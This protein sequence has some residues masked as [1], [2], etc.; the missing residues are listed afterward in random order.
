MIRG[1]H[2]VLC[3]VCGRET[4]ALVEGLCPQCF[5]ARHPLIQKK[6]ELTIQHC[7]VCGAYRFGNSAWIQETSALEEELRKRMETFLVLGGRISEAH[8][9][10]H[11]RSRVLEVRVRGVAFGLQGEPYWESY[12]LPFRLL[13]TLCDSC[14][15]HRA[16]KTAAVVQ[17]R[18]EDRDLTV[19]ERRAVQEVLLNLSEESRGATLDWIPIK[20][21]N[22]PHGV[23][24]HFTSY[25]AARG[26]VKLLSE[27][28]FFN[29]LE[30]NKLIGVTHSGRRKHLQTIRL[31]L[32]KFKRGDV[33]QLKGELY[34]VEDIRASKAILL[35]VKKLDRATIPLSRSTLSKIT[36]YAPGDT[37]E[38]GIILSRY[39]NTV[40]V[41]SVLS[42]N[43]FEVEGQTLENITPGNRVLLLR[44]G[45]R[46]F[47]IPASNGEKSSQS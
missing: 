24:V 4:D 41:M 43:V 9:K 23:D 15:R 5:R 14:V 20:V 42:N 28:I 33:I 7:R 1:M 16:R 29:V 11:P 30:T 18:A 40:Q 35:D 44:I 37:L 12:T 6:K 38:Q 8:F 45:E 21:E 47:L 3:P 34:F 25:D 26:F 22:V 10:L 31:L 19:G 13:E 27:K 17:I 36:V 46:V 32:P 39:G 2:R